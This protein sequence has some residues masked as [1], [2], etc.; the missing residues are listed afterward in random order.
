[1]GAG[2]IHTKPP[3]PSRRCRPARYSVFESLRTY[4]RRPFHRDEHLERL[5]RSAEIIELT[6]PY[7]HEF[8]ASI[9]HEAIARNVYKHASIRILGNGRRE[10]GWHSPL[11]SVCPGC[12]D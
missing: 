7:T 9:I 1:M 8:I 2:S 5:Y 12:I 6:V 3:S 10:R 11:W 4:N